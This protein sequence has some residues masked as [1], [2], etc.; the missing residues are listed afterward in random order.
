MKAISLA[1]I[2]LPLASLAQHESKTTTPA[3][4]STTDCPDFK[5]KPQTSKAAYFESLRHKPATAAAT[6]AKK[7]TSDKP[8]APARAKTEK[9]YVPSFSSS[10]KIMEEKKAPAAKTEVKEKPAAEK[11]QVKQNKQLAENTAEKPKADKK[12]VKKKTS[13]TGSGKVRGTKKN[14]ANCPAF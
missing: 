14:A 11:P 5:N 10:D 6:P 4:A 7:G 2:L 13:D 3:K 9:A 12:P 8:A 1:F